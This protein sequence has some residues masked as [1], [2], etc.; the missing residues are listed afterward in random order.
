MLEKWKLYINVE[1]ITVSQHPNNVCL[2]TV[3]QRQKS[4]LFSHNMMLE[5][6]KS[7]YN[8]QVITVFQHQNY[9]SLSMSNQR[10]NLMF[11]QRWLWVDSKMKLCSYIM[12]LEKLKSVHQSWK[13][14]RI[15]TSKQRQFIN[16]KSMSKLNVATTLILGWL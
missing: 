3:I 13:D 12:K 4:T 7:L 2:S 10:L 15:S 11:K 5:K 9:V 1:K 8:V 16:V 6:S 14:N